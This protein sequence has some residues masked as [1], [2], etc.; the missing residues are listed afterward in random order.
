[1]SNDEKYPFE[2]KVNFFASANFKRDT[3]VPASIEM[4]INSEINISEP[5][6]PVLQVGLKV[7]SPDDSPLFFDVHLIGIFEYQEDASQ[8]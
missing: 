5:G 2:L 7:K 8:S 6:F 1:M 4:Q 3:E